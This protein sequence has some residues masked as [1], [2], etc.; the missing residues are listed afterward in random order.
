M[1]CTPLLG[2]GPHIYQNDREGKEKKSRELGGTFDPNNNVMTN[3]FS[4]N[5]ESCSKMG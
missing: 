5:S 4:A 3:F 2:E 1:K